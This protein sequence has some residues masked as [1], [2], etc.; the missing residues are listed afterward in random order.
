[1]EYYAVLCDKCHKYSAKQQ[2]NLK[3]QYQVFKCKYC[4]KTAK[5]KHKSEFG[6]HL[7]M[8]GP[9]DSNQISKVISNLNYG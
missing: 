8:F 4:G 5:M 6:L 1:M 3:L 9:Y 2:F 7:K